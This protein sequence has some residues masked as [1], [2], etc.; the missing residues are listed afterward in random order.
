MSRESRIK[1]RTVVVGYLA[2][3]ERLILHSLFTTH[4]SLFLVH[5][6]GRCSARGR[7]DTTG[8]WDATLSPKRTVK[9][10]F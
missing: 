3:F 6:K 9:K 4:D 5:T 7:A 2:D 10:D 8:A 1:A